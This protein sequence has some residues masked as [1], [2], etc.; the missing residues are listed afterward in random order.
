MEQDAVHPEK[1]N[2]PL[3]SGAASR[4]GAI[5]LAILLMVGG[6]TLAYLLE[7]MFLLIVI[8]YFINSQL[9]NYYLRRWAVVDVITIAV[10]F[11]LR[12]IAGTFLIHVPFTSWLIIGV[13]FFALV[14]GF[15]KRLNELQ[16]LGEDAA[17]H[18]PVFK[19]YNETMLNHGITVS[20]TWVIFFYTLYCYE[21]FKDVMQAQPVLLT[22]PV[23][24]GIIL[25][26]IYLIFSGSPVGRNPHLAFKD[27]GILAGA[28]LFAITLLWT[29]FF[30][31]PI[32][33]FFNNLFPPLQ[34]G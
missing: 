26:Y 31:G 32:F 25:R 29:V 8:L 24:A 17:D 7:P 16:L 13:F 14:L 4:D 1:R 22:V 10:G 27:K 11:I 12:A 30:W 5:G 6:L 20:A 3:P 15:G 34:Q 23:A 2:R 33:E 19:Q 28:I 18:K 21:N 9:Y